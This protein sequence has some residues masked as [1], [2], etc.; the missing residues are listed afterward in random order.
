MNDLPYNRHLSKQL[1][2][3]WLLQKSC[4]LIASATFNEKPVNID[5]ID[6]LLSHAFFEVWSYLCSK[7]QRVDSNLCAS[8]I[9]LHCCGHETL[10]EEHCWNPI[11]THCVILHPFLEECHSLNEIIYPW[12]ERLQW[13]ICSILPNLRYLLI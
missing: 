13:W 10:R 4:V 8:C 2:G 12:S 5:S 11:W 3:I 6:R 1:F 9:W 7:H